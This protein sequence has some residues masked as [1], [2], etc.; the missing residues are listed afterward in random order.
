MYKKFRSTY[1]K[2][3]RLNEFKQL[4]IKYPKRIPI[5]IDLESKD[6]V[7][8]KRKYLA[9]SEMLF[10]QFQHVIRQQ[11]NIG[12]NDSLF[13]FYGWTIP[14]PTHSLAQIYKQHPT[15]DGF[16]VIKVAKENTFGV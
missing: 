1:S 2:E 12:P 6:L 13:F 7:L 5:V 16:M 9:E 3:H 10:C 8:N 4:T 14:C 15:E 11:M